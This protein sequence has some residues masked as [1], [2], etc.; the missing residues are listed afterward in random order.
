MVWTY[1]IRLVPQVE[2]NHNDTN[3]IRF[4]DMDIAEKL[5]LGFFFS[6]GVESEFRSDD[7]M[8]AALLAP[9]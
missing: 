4:L 5:K 3:E 6:V 9:V 7:S 8:T 1:I 2:I